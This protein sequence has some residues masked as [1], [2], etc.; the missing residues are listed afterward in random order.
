MFCVVIVHFEMYDLTRFYSFSKYMYQNVTNN[1]Y[2]VHH[3]L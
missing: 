1:P 3:F 2:S